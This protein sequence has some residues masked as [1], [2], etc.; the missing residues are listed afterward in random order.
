[1]LFWPLSCC[2]MTLVEA[3]PAVNAT[4]NAA[5]GV[6]LLTAYTLIRQKKIAQH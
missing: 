4:L 3:L 2:F 5:S 1:M 6:L